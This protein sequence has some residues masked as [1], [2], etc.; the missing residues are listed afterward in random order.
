MKGNVVYNMK[1]V[2]F[3]DF[4]GTLVY[5]NSLWSKSA[6]KAMLDVNP[7]STITWEELRP[8]MQSGYTWDT[9]ENDYSHLIGEAW[10]EFMFQKMD[11]VYKAFG[12]E[13]NLARKASM[14]MREIILDVSNYILYQDT[15]STLQTAL[16]LGYQNV[17]LSNNYP[18]LDEIMKKLGLNEYF[19]DC[20]VSACVGYDKP[21]VELFEYA[22]K[23]AGYPEICYM[24]GDNTIADIFGGKRVGMKTILVHKKVECEADYICENLSNIFH[25]I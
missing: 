24:I 7:S 8:Y 11:T 18:E 10:W 1:K 19:L 14:R 4:D 16:T 22:K 23:A 9:P 15:I 20:V 25:I 21:R 12:M 5:S 6:H 13:K 2:L 3:W 17:L